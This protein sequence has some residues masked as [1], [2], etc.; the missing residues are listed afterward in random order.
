MNQALLIEKMNT[1]LTVNDF[2]HCQSTEEIVEVIYRLTLQTLRTNQ[3]I[4]DE[5]GKALYA[6]ERL[7][8]LSKE[9]NKTELLLELYQ[10]GQLIP[11]LIAV[12]KESQSMAEQIE[13]HLIQKWK[14]T[15]DLKTK[16][17]LSWISQMNNLRQ[18]VKEQVRENLIYI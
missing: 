7:E 5:I 8:F 10:T 17:M 1:T 2:S 4:R 13:S 3:Q 9:E 18:S 11:H 16:D 6:K 14:L 12:E 15:E